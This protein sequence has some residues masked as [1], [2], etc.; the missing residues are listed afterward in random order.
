MFKR[1]K[2]KQIG[3][4]HFVSPLDII[5]ILIVFGEFSGPVHMNL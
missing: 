2:K 4:L 3:H 5:D 1:T